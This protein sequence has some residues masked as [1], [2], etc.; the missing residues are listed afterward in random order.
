MQGRT[1]QSY[2]FDRAEV[3][4]AERALLIDGVRTEL[5][6]RAF[7]VLL[8]LI[9]N[10]GRVVTKDELLDLV[11]PGL[12]VQENNLQA[13]VSTLRKLLGPNAIVTI[14]A[15]GYQFSLAE[16]MLPEIPNGVMPSDIPSHANLSPQLSVQG[17]PEAVMAQ[18]PPSTLTQA[19]RAAYSATLP[20][21]PSATLLH[22]Q[23]RCC[24]LPTSPATPMMST[25]PTASP[26][27]C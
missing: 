16:T 15:R 14:P 6:S 18:D 12:V 22:F 10:R 25:Y 20:T 23:L 27:S 2:R 21:T 9:K 8:A 5:G 7:D 13:Q 11:W 4:P 3:R 26:M 17:N 1:L 24:R 19:E